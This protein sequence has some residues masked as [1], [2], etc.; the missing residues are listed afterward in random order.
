M[1][2]G[3]LDESIVSPLSI[4]T[5]SHESGATEVCEVPR[6]LRLIRFEN[7]DAIADAQLLVTEQMNKAQAGAVSQGFEKYFET[8]VHSLFDY[9]FGVSCV[10]RRKPLT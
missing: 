10:R 4:A 6:N 8:V 7:L 3:R 5:R 1:R 2:I 9:D